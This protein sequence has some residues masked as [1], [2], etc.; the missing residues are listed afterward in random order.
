MIKKLHHVGIVVKD[1]DK[2]VE[3]Y[4][5]MLGVKPESFFEIR[6]AKIKIANFKVGETALEFLGPMPGNSLENFTGYR[7]EGLHHIAF[8]VDDIGE[9]L[10]KQAELG[11]KLV[12]MEPRPGPEGDIAFIGPEG[13][14]GV[15][16]ELVQPKEKGE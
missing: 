2:A 14:H 13:A 12:D 16:I 10:K 7:G 8:E 11:V 5:A 1:L 6:D 15:Y 3:L 9:E 4:T